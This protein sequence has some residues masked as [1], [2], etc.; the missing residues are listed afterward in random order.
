MIPYTSPDSQMLPP[1][2][3]P[4]SAETT[5]EHRRGK[6]WLRHAIALWLVVV[7]AASVKSIIEPRFHTVYT[8]FSQASRD[9]WLAQS[10]YAGREFFYSP[11]FAVAM[12]PL[13]HFARLAG[14]DRLDLDKLRIAG[15]R[16]AS[17]LS[18]CA[19]GNELARCGGGTISDSRVGRHGAQYLVG[20]EQRNFDRDGLVGGCGDRP[21]QMVASGAMVGGADSHQS[22]ASRCR[23]T[24]KRTLAAAAGRPLGAV[25]R[26]NWHAAI[27]SARAVGRRRSICRLVSVP[28]PSTSRRQPLLRLSRRLDDLG[29]NPRTGQSAPYLALQAGLGL[30]ILAWCFWQRHRKLPARQLVVYTIAAWSIWQLLMGPGTERLTYNIIA[31]ALA[32]GVLTAWHD[33][34]RRALAQPGVDNRRLCHHLFIGRRR[35][36]TTADHLVPGI[37]RTGADRRA[38]FCRLARLA[39]SIRRALV[40]RSISAD[41]I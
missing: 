9:W 18:H 8:T 3:P 4:R 19:S 28:R 24:F 11:A 30:A 34:G 35:N 21:R 16:L 27:S 40:R 6:Q 36:G 23:R 41:A 7:F 29:A 37:D 15:L 25:R 39:R 13:A 20:A 31:P 2:N 38:D 5:S 26:R 10:L 12:T 1:L 14:C 17:L 32:W 33:A 22:V